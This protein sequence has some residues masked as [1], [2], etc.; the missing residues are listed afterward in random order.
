MSKHEGKLQQNITLIEAIAFSV[1]QIIGTGIFLKPTA[2]FQ[3]T[4]STGISLLVWLAAGV[5]TLCTALTIAEVASYKPMIGGITSYVNEYNG[6]TL[7]FM[8]GWFFSILN[9][10]GTLAANTI[11]TATFISAVLP[12]NNVQIKLCAF[13]ILWGLSL[14]QMF[15][16]KGT[17]RF[18]LLGAVIQAAPIAIVVILGLLNGANANNINLSLIGD[19]NSPGASLGIALLGAMW[20]YDGWQATANLGEEMVNP[21]RDFPKAIFYSISFL[22]ILFL[23]FNYVGF[24]LIPAEELLNSQNIGA[25]ISEKLFGQHGVLLMTILMVICSTFTM[26]A[27]I[28]QATRDVLYQARQNNL[29]GAKWI[30]HIHPK[31]DTPINAIIFQG[32]L[33]TIVMLT[34]TFESISLLIIFFI[35]IFILFVLWDVFKLRKQKEIQRSFSTPLFPITPIIGILGG[36]FMLLSAVS[37]NPMNFVVG[38]IVILMGFPIYYYCHNVLYKGEKPVE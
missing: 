17:M 14:S 4:H 13:I 26:N 18:Q 31:T 30:R 3:A 35:W 24:K 15:S 16:V 20:V 22:I 12:M 5:I 21:K 10:P 28:V 2:I 36:L 23:A 32:I 11:A 9:N 7:G 1:G 38:L 8:S 33:S 29:I 27:E 25:N 6:K 34:G 37:S 19:P